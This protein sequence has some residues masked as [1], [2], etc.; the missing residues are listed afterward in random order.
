[1]GF[2]VGLV[3][4]DAVSDRML[5]DLL[6]IALPLEVQAVYLSAVKSFEVERFPCGSPN[7]DRLQ[8]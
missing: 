6:E 4:P 3:E 7:A 2:N 1:M 5:T 8:P